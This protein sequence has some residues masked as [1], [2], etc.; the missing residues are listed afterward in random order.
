[1]SWLYVCRLTL[2]C[3]FVKLYEIRGQ[4]SCY[5]RWIM[6]VGNTVGECSE[7]SNMQYQMYEKVSC[8]GGVKPEMSRWIT[9]RR[10]K[11]LPNVIS[12]LSFMLQKNHSNHKKVYLDI[13][14]TMQ[15]LLLL[16]TEPSKKMLIFSFISVYCGHRSSALFPRAT[17]LGKKAHSSFLRVQQMILSLVDL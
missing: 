2:K 14:L 8:C 13:I 15:L 10:I 3:S 6:L 4:S 7:L 16:N 12:S 1:M 11:D 5:V 9:S 17:S